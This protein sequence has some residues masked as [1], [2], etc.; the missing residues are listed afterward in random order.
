MINMALILRE[1]AAIVGGAPVGDPA[2]V[3]ACAAE[4]RRCAQRLQ[5]QL[6]RVHRSHAS[7]RFEGPGARRFAH[8]VHEVEASLARRVHELEE[9]AAYLDGAAHRLAADQRA[10]QQRAAR[11]KANLTETAMQAA[12]AA[13]HR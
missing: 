6:P 1:V 8:E 13:G 7:L 9:I 3:R 11:I 12:R 2:A 4:H 10:H 5:A